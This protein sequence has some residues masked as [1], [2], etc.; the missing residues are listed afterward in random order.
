MKHLFSSILAFSFFLFGYGQSTST[1]LSNDAIEIVDELSTQLSSDYLY[2][3]KAEII[4]KGLKEYTSQLNSNQQFEIQEFTDAVNAIMLDATSDHHLKLYF[5]PQKF[6][7]FQA[8]N[9]TIIDSLEREQYRRVNFGVQKVENITNNI[10]LLR[11]N[12]FQQ[13][14]DVQ[15][16]LL[17]AMMT[18]ANS[19]AVII[20]LRINGG[21]DGR[22]K[23]YLESFF[24]SKEEFFNRETEFIDTTEFRTI[25]K[26]CSSC[27]R[28]E[29]ISIYLLTGNGTFSA[30]EGFCYDLQQSGRAQIIGTKTKGGGHS[31]SSIALSKG[32][33]VFIPVSGKSSPI[34]GVGISPNQ[35][36]REDLALLSAKK[37]IIDGFISECSDSVLLQQYK[38]NGQTID[39]LLTTKKPETNAIEPF[40]GEYS[41]GFSV[42]IIDDKLLLVNLVKEMKSELVA[43][44]ERYFIVSDENDFGEGNYRIQ[45]LDG[46]KAK[47]QVNLG[48][49]VAEMPL[50]KK[51]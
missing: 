19:D 31:G 25:K 30:A 32:F 1:I 41:N 20:D 44:N 11:L 14:E 22:T 8:N 10:G 36:T 5:D 42:Q 6:E 28:L 37:L 26:S 34:E 39:A 2:P 49:K 15:E 43:I 3:K 48:V 33:L 7:T 29:E 40:I 27:L 13:Y 35:E 4:V 9:E 16:V 12:K 46:G 50:E 24:F 21:G 51:N 23:E 17:G 18:L 45:F 47:L 38:W